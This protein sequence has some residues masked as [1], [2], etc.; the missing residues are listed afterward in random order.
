MQARFCADLADGFHLKQFDVD[1]PFA[2]TEDKACLNI[3]AIQS[4]MEKKQIVLY[5]YMLFS[6]EY[7]RW[8]KLNLM[9]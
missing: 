6:A 7:I 2:K 5:D 4:A 3:P 1:D 9:K 8:L